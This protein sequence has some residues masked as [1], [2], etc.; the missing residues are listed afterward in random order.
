MSVRSG[1]WNAG[2]VGESTLASTHGSSTSD[3]N[4][5]SVSPGRSK[6]LSS[7]PA[8]VYSVHFNFIF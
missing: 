6:S 3:V 7:S 1:R 5:I 4:V 2:L 8:P